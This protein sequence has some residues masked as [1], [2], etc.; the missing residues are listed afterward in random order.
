[1]S[2]QLVLGTLVIIVLAP[3]AAG[4]TTGTALRA[5]P[6]VPEDK[7]V[8]LVVMLDTHTSVIAVSAKAAT[9]VLASEPG[10]N[11][12]LLESVDKIPV[13]QAADFVAQVGQLPG[14]LSAEMLRP[15]GVPEIEACGEP[16]GTSAQQCSI[17]FA[18]GSPSDDEFHSQEALAYMPYGKVARW[19]FNQ[20]QPVLV[21]VIDTGI[22]PGHPALVGHV[23]QS[24]WDFVSG[25][26]GA[27]DVANGLDDDHD[28]W[29]DE[30]Y[31]HGTFLASVV[32]LINPD[33]SILPLRVLD[34]DG[35]GNSFNVAD[36]I[37]YA[38]DHGA[39]VINLSLSMSDPSSAVACAMEYARYK[40]AAIY[41]AAGNTSKEK[42]LFPA[43][44][45]P[46]IFKWGPCLPEDWVPSA[47]TV[48][49]VAS[50]DAEGIKADFSAWGP[51]VDIV[52]PG[53][54]IYGAMPG[55][56]YAW[57]SGTSMSAAVASGVG[58]LVDSVVGAYAL[59]HGTPSVIKV[60]AW[61]VDKINQAYTGGLGEG[62][63]NAA[64]ASYAAWV[65]TQP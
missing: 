61:S 49:A 46:S 25:R 3:L 58:S 15:V 60:T 30:S 54:G 28:G 4:Q 55:G 16:L 51:E 62:F 1:M 24:G 20:H 10:V 33:A 27:I 42:V 2:R 53:I 31:G 38:A 64:K 56:G 52:T 12:H 17:S 45:D 50:T 57:W 6:Q 47:A 34:A 40:G 14:V 22:D 32:M 59:Q 8:E 43:N 65:L 7:C 35:N 18:D 23:A 48:T 36:A 21:A 26:P 9:Q 63:V 29:I 37:Y 44:Y 13:S 39:Q 5:P 41:V 19:S 11:M